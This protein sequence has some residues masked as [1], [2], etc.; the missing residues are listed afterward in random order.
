MR[1]LVKNTGVVF[2][3]LASRDHQLEQQIVNGEHTFHAAA[4]ASQAFAEAFHALPAFEHNSRI[5]LK[6]IDKFAEVANPYF[7]EFRPT[8]HQLS[9]L[10]KAAKPF[11]PEFNKF[12]TS[13]GPLTKAA[14][15]GLPDVKK[16]PRPD[17]S[18]PRKPSSGAAQPRPVPA[19]HGRLRA[20]AAGVLREPRGRLAVEPERRQYRRILLERR[21]SQCAPRLSGRH[22][23]ADAEDPLPDDDGGAQCRK[24]GDLPGKVATNRSNAYPLPGTYSSLAS[25]LPV[26]STK[27]CSGEAPTVSGPAN[28]TISEEII[29]QLQQFKVANK[30]GS[31]NDIPAPA[32]TQQGPFTFNGKTSQFPQVVYGGKK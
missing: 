3:A 30:Q 25:G 29:Q 20:R 6:E 8:E 27:G 17:G 22:S 24:P 26:F 19:V 1:K 28:E 10:L 12:L 21:Q 13:L 23:S 4:Q 31:P 9:K 11:A 14:K 2:S 5:A 7:E 32:C 18:D 16:T 15:T